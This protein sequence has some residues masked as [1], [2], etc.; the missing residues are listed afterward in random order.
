VTDVLDV[1]RNGL[2]RLGELRDGVERAVLPPAGD[3]GDGL[4]ATARP[5]LELTTNVTV[6]TM[7]RTTQARAPGATDR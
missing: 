2:D 4:A 6:S 1:A 7:G 5:M 3:I